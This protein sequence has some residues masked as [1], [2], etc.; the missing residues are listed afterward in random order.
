MVFM[1]VELIKQFQ[2]LGMQQQI[3]IMIPYFIVFIYHFLL[4]TAY[5]T[6]VAGFVYLTI[7]Y[8]KLLYH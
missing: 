6:F 7:S 3:R 8:L 4:Y 1:M 5:I 2:F